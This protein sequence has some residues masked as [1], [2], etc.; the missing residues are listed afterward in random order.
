[1]GATISDVQQAGHPRRGASTA[2]ALALPLP[3]QSEPLVRPAAWSG[4]PRLRLGGLG[5]IAR[6][7]GR[8][9][10]RAA[11]DH[12]LA[13]LAKS[14]QMCASRAEGEGELLELE[15]PALS[16]VRLGSL[17]AQI[18]LAP[19]DFR[20]HRLVLT[21][22]PCRSGEEIE[23]PAA[24]GQARARAMLDRLGAA[25][26]VLGTGGSRGLDVRWTPVTPLGEASGPLYY[27]MSLAA[28]GAQDIGLTEFAGS[29]GSAL[30]PAAEFAMVEAALGELAARP[31]ICVSI[32]LSAAWLED[33]DWQEALAL[34]IVEAR[35][36]SARLILSMTADRGD[37][38]S[39]TTF[40]ARL[41]RCGAALGVA[42]FGASAMPL[43]DLIAIA[44]DVIEL[45]GQLLSGAVS[46][47][48]YAAALPRMVALAVSL[49]P[50]VVAAGVNT[51][52]IS[53]LAAASGLE[54]GWG[55][56]LRCAS[57]SRPWHVLRL[58]SG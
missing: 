32:A 29:G 25:V 43:T 37:R 57:I 48:R 3:E 58:I 41:R 30:A 23:D 33:P 27:R 11:R 44:P 35:A 17:A 45:S 15:G 24:P 50:I 21:A 39:W 51:P 8:P 53:E 40:A 7:Y 22:S 56:S 55:E 12:A 9:A 47:E 2:A 42:R 31:D 38:G 16:L 19:F 36:D 54:W 18:T 52:A 4:A 46:A 5:L 10:V 14:G 13:V 28:S 20:G 26:T 6:A 49:S 1:M 34:R